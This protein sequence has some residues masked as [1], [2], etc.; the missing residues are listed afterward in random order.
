MAKRFIDTDLFRK[1]LMRSLE[2]PYKA[3]WIYL[4]CECDHAGVWDV[5]LDVAQIRMGMTID[6]EKAVEKLGG[7]VVVID[8]GAKWWLPEFVQFQ[9]GTLNPANRVHAS[10]IS[11]LSKH[12]IDPNAEREN[13][14]LVRPLTRA[15][16]KAKEKDKD[17]DKEQEGGAG[18]TKR[19]GPD[20]EVQ[21]VITYLTNAI[22]LKK[23][24]QSLDV[25]EVHTPHGKKDGN[26]LAA[27]NLLNK[28]KTDYPL[29]DPLADAKLIIDYAT[30][31]QFHRSHCTR[32]RYL[33]KHC[34]TLIAQATEKAN[35]HT[36]AKGAPVS[37]DEAARRTEEYFA[38]KR[39]SGGVDA[40]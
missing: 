5:E 8:G 4:L 33:H 14:G 13:K 32:V 15:K 18:E 27:Y 30:E 29:H 34:G 7:A 35:G 28:L 21:E 39:A 36:S 19:K 23:I 22:R 6:P 26:R 1:P 24:A 17:K 25:D 20:P 9:Y 3:L 11:V 38:R 16:D 2:A 31:D 10:V 40:Q 37:P 12:G